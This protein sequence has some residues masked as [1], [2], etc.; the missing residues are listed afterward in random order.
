M[1]VV[2]APHRAPHTGTHG[3]HPASAQAEVQLTA[4]FSAINTFASA[5]QAVQGMEAFGVGV[6]GVGAG[7]GVGDGGG[8]GG[9]GGG[10]RQLVSMG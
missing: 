9:L 1:P 5:V 3:T 2:I 6:G 7:V 4:F 10:D 8:V